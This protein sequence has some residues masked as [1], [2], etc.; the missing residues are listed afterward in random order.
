PTSLLNEPSEDLEETEQTMIRIRNDVSL[1]SPAPVSEK[2]V[3]YDGKNVSGNLVL[4]QAGT[5]YIAAGRVLGPAEDGFFIFDSN[6]FGGEVVSG[7]AGDEVAVT[8]SISVTS[9]SWAIGVFRQMEDIPT[10]AP[11]E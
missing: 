7:Q 8:I 3:T 10:A 9:G 11:A 4:N 2:A 6:C 5:Y 1:E